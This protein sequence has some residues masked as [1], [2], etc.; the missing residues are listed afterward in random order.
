MKAASLNEI[1]KQLATLDSSDLEQICAALARYKKEN[2]EL[3]TYLLFEAQDEQAY[4]SGI[5]E[6]LDELFTNVPKTN[7]YF[8]K[9]NIRKIL[10]ILNKQVRYSAVVSTELEARIYF[11]LKMKETV[12]AL[13]HGT[14]L[15][16]LYQ[17]Q[18]KKIRGLLS[19]LPED[20]Q[21]D[22]ELDMRK[23]DL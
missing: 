14:V 8:V 17:Q 3:L 12:T 4:L 9:K 5:R 15:F 10:R 13:H 11:C 19:K 20:L 16:N 1:R 2:K 22:Y 21:F 18:L 23:I 6:E 7:V